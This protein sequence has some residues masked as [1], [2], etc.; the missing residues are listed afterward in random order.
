M[1]KSA[2]NFNN[3]NIKENNKK[4]KFRKLNT[5]DNFKFK[6]IKMNVNANN[7][8][9]LHNSLDLSFIDNYYNKMNKLYNNQKNDKTLFYRKLMERQGSKSCANKIWKNENISYEKR[10]EKDYSSIL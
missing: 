1:N 5:K 9:M 10:K 7:K 2:D 8:R 3:N 6:N 4:D